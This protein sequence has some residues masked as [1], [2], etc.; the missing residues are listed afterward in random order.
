MSITASMRHGAPAWLLG[1]ALIIILATLE[2]KG[3]SALAPGGSVQPLFPVAEFTLTNGL[4]LLVVEDHHCPIVAVQVWYHVGSVDEPEGRRGFAHLFEHLMFRGTDRL[5]PTDH[6]DLLTGVGGEDNAFTDFDETCYHESLPAQQLELAFWLESERMA[7][8]TIDSAGMATERKVVEEERRMYLNQPYGDLIDLGLPVLF[9]QHP[10]ANAPIGT[11]HDLRLATTADVHSWWTKRYTPNNATLVVVGDVKAARVQDLARRYFGWIPAVPQPRRDIPE[12]D[13][14]EAASQTVLKLDNAPAPG[15]AVTWRTVAEGHPDAVAL[16]LLAS[17]L[18]GGESSRLYRRLVVDDH[19]AVAAMAMAYGLRK[20]GLFGVGAVLSPAGGD[21]ARVQGILQSEI[22][23]VIEQ[24]VTPEEL[25]KAQNQAVS[26][27]VQAIQ[28]DNGKATLIGR[29]AV[30]GP[31]IEELETRLERLRRLTPVDLRRVAKTYLDPSHSLTVTIPGSSLL[32]QLSRLFLGRRRAE[33]A[34]PVT[35]PTGQA[36]HGRPGVIRP[37]NLP[38][39][40]P[41]KRGNP[42][43]PKL[44]P[45][46]YRLAN[47]LRVLIATTPGA[48][49]AEFVLALPFGAWAESKPGTAAL[50]LRMLTKGT[51][52]HDEKTITEDLERHA[53]QLTGSASHDESRLEVRCLPEQVEIALRWMG[54]II[55]H[56]SFPESALRTT[57]SQAQA[58]LAVAD[59]DP[60]AVAEREFRRHLFAAHPYA[61]RISGESAELASLRSEDLSSFWGRIADPAQATLIVASPLSEKRMLALCQRFLANW[62]LTRTFQPIPEPAVP[63]HDSPTHIVLVNWPGAGQSEIRVGGPGLVNR[64]TALPIAKLISSYF[65]GSF[66]SRLM[67]AVRVDEGATYGINGGFHPGRLAG[68]FEVR[69][70]TKTPATAGTLRLVLGQIRALVEDPPTVAELRLHRR[71]FLGSAASWFETPGQIADR[72]TGIALNALPLDYV[73]RT[74]GDISIAT[75]SRCVQLT[76]RI[77]DPEHLLIVVVGDAAV[78]LADLE[79]IAPVTVLDRD[80]QRP[81]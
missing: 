58:E 57:I 15:V 45:A 80:G 5:G 25:E 37:V 42:P 73:Q 40:P 16:D 39:R 47:G 50:T 64:D 7:F 54:E 81:N 44:R 28:T 32:G 53:I 38:I 3:D 31:G 61:R 21:T 62:N 19:L 68:M 72:F 74:L 12:A 52:L 65:G 2:V 36:F 56:A 66:G 10:Y 1:S 48:P 59:N 69:T 18:G 29:A 46:E 8:L 6:S 67:R 63:G 20:G 75:A 14:F 79:Q 49:T 34:T 35:P 11:I 33:E 22:A 70:F 76:K 27:L 60:A 43:I 26:Q 77:V 41:I 55:N 30:V 4:Q 23:R 71:Y 78:T 24:G 9:G 13:R 51:D 17:I